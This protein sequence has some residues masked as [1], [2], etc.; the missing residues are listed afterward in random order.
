[1]TVK[2]P[3]EGEDDHSDNMK[4]RIQEVQAEAWRPHRFIDAETEES[5]AFFQENFFAGGAMGQNTE[6]LLAKIPTLTSGVNDEQYL[7]VISA[8]IDKDRLTK[9]R[10]AEKEAGKAR[11]V[12]KKKKNG[13]GKGMEIAVSGD[14]DFSSETLSESEGAEAGAYVNGGEEAAIT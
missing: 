3:G 1:M 7:D 8:P 2:S 5:W 11:R 12:E 6:D 4:K 14:N 13:K 9:A 10:D